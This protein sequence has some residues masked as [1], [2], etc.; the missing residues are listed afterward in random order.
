[1]RPEA[2]PDDLGQ[3]PGSKPSWDSGGG[4]A[5]PSLPRKEREKARHRREVLRAAERL[6]CTRS[7]TEIGVQ[8]IAEA[9]EFSVGYLYRLFPSKEDIFAS[10]I[11]LR[12]DELSRLTDGCLEREGNAEERLRDFVYAVFDWLQQNPGYTSSTVRELLLISCVLP[13]LATEFALWDAKAAA[14]T[15]SLFEDGIRE[16]VFGEHEDPEIMAKTLKV[17]MKGL[18]LEDLFHGREK[19]D[20]TE[21]TPI[22]MRIMMRAFGPEGGRT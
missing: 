17:L 4:A 18:I 10:L 1:M 2:S 8:E 7:Y 9:A 3:G 5:D 20:W 6:L 12:H 14:R 15:R 11:R 13:G 22:V 19:A 21:Y 16:G